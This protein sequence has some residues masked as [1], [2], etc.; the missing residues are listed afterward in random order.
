MASSAGGLK[1]RQR[2]A[3]SELVR[4]SKRSEELLSKKERVTG[5]KTDNSDSF[6]IFVLLEL[7]R[8]LAGVGGSSVGS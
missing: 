4:L 2:L 5:D 7:L 8:D 6:C 3:P 1:F